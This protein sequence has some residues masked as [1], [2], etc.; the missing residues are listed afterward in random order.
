MYLF[1]WCDSSSKPLEPVEPKL[2]PVLLNF[3]LKKPSGRFSPPPGLIRPLTSD[4]CGPEADRRNPAAPV[5]LSSRHVTEDELNSDSPALWIIAGYIK[6]VAN[7]YFIS[8]RWLLVFIIFS[9]ASQDVRLMNCETRGVE[10]KQHKRSSDQIYTN[11]LKMKSVYYLYSSCWKIHEKKNQQWTDFINWYIFF[12]W[13][14]PDSK[15][16]LIHRLK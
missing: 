5:A 6:M 1:P 16:R 12:L 15:F 3:T 13:A 7:Y 14:R 11:I 2:D 4:P 8:H 10:V 9:V